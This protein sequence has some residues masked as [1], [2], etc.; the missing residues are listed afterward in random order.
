LIARS[1]GGIGEKLNLV[2]MDGKLNIGAWRQME[3]GWK[4]DI[5]AGKKVEVSIELSYDDASV[6]PRKFEV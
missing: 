2:P 3:R 1:L 5:D 4:N 6:R